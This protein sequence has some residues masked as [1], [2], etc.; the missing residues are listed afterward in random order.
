MTDE[1]NA[2]MMPVVYLKE[3]LTKVGAELVHFSSN[4][5]FERDYER[6]L[7]SISVRLTIKGGKKK[8]IALIIWNLK[9]LGVLTVGNT[10]VKIKDSEGFT[11]KIY[12]ERVR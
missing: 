11:H 7:P 12:F 5:K 4:R 9:P 6:A 10:K 8:D 2:P 3:E 1:V